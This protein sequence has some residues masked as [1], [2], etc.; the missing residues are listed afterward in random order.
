MVAIIS[1]LCGH[2]QIRKIR[3]QIETTSSQ[4]IVLY[5]S[6]FLL[7]SIT[8]LHLVPVEDKTELEPH[9]QSRTSIR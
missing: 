2:M 9:P 8:S 5:S 4:E 6:K 7:A 3:V 1:Q